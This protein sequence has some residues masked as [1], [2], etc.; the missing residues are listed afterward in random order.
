MLL[1]L[2]GRPNRPTK[3][4]PARR[5]PLG[6]H[7]RRQCHS[8]LKP[9]ISAALAPKPGGPICAGS[10]GW[11]ALSRAAEPREQ[12]ASGQPI[13]LHASRPLR[14]EPNRTEP[15]AAQKDTTDTDA[16]TSR[17]ATNS[18]HTNKPA[19]LNPTRRPISQIAG[20]RRYLLNTCSCSCFGCYFS[21]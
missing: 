1:A 4:K 16:S 8:P 19:K 17:S 6:R 14:T 12:K 11:P 21:C 7:S 10:S 20:S 5:W 15:T 2:V 9:P 3:T 13:N 18:P